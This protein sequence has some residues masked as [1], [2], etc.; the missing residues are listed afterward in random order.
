MSAAADALMGIFGFKRVIGKIMKEA[1]RYD[2][3]HLRYD[4]SNIR[5]GEGC[6]VEVVAAYDYDELKAVSR[7]LLEALER[8]VYDFES[9]IH[10]EYDG[11]SMLSARLA[12]C[13]YARAAIAKARGEA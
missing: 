3:V 11:T 10:N 7:E 5:Y 2:A 12:E 9:E 6:E 13:D 4:D 8:L 1:K